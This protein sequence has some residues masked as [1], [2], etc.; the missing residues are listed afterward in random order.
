MKLRDLLNMI[1]EG[2]PGS[3]RKSTTGTGRHSAEYERDN[4][5]RKAEVKKN[6]KL[7]KVKGRMRA[8]TIAKHMRGFNIGQ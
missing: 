1:N 3:G 5:R 4:A 7:A 6:P 8:S 2:G